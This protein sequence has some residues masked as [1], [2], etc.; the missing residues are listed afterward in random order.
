M[1]NTIFVDAE[2]MAAIKA[3]LLEAAISHYYGYASGVWDEDF[4][5]EKAVM[6]ITPES[7]T[8][9]I[10][11]TPLLCFHP[12]QT[13]IIIEGEAVKIELRQPCEVLY[14]QNQN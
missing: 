5:A 13:N 11:G 3:R 1:R 2:Q 7:E 14:E 10:D 12:Y 9:V 4:L 6:E 8:F